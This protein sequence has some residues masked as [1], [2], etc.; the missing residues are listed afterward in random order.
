MANFIKNWTNHEIERLT[1]SFRRHSR[2]VFGLKFLLPLAALA[3]IALLIIYPQKKD[4]SKQKIVLVAQEQKEAEKS[5]TP[6]ME[7]PKFHGVD[8]DNQPYQITAKRAMQSTKTDVTMIDITADLMMSNGDFLAL[9]AESGV[10]DR[11]AGFVQLYGDVDIFLSG[12]KGEQEKS[13]EIKTKDTAIDITKKT[14]IGEHP[15]TVESNIGRFEAQGFR[16]TRG[17]NKINFKG[18]VKLVILR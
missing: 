6:E 5:E 15:V 1:R 9:V 12:G 2:F 3:M 7:N 17:D 14:V 11:E 16:I 18:P 10:Y 13:Y 8:S 4:S